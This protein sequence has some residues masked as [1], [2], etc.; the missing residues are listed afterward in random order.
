MNDENQTW[1]DLPRRRG[2]FRWIVALAEVM[3]VF[4]FVSQL[5]QKLYR[6]TELPFADDFLFVEDADPDFLAAIPFELSYDA[7]TFG[8]VIMAVLLTGIVRGRTSLISYGFYREPGRFWELLRLGV[9]AGAAIYCIPNLLK[10]IDHYVADIG[11]GTSFWKLQAQVSWGW[12]YWLFMAV[13]GFLVI[14]IIEEF[15]VRGYLLGRL[16]ENFRPGEAIII[17]AFL[18]SSAHLQ[19]LKPDVLSIGS[20]IGIVLN[21][22]LLGYIVY[23]TGSILPGMIAHMFVNLPATPGWKVLG[24][25]AAAVCLGYF[26]RR[27]SKFVREWLS[28]TVQRTDLK[29]I[30]IALVFVFITARAVTGKLPYADVWYGICI[31]LFVC[32]LL[33]RSTWGNQR[34]S[35]KVDSP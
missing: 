12:E 31:A 16:N 7:A 21:S 8:L 29:T 32:S 34:V 23:R 3:V 15:L 4:F 24:I 13:A 27:V 28:L 17:S 30:A 20:S 25:V 1:I 26:H 18:F 11:P 9:M 6:W 35:T 5:G 2:F 10:V 33:M 22:L 19:Y 14:P